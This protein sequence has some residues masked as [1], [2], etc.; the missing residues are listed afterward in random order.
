MTGVFIELALLTYPE[1]GLNS[2]SA[3][4]FFISLFQVGMCR[5]V[6]RNHVNE[7]ARHGIVAHRL[8]KENLGNITEIFV[9]DS[10]GFVARSLWFHCPNAISER[11]NFGLLFSLLG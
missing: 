4:S 2:G 3:I 9:N 10:F 8:W 5:V 7:T 6:G 1:A 11:K